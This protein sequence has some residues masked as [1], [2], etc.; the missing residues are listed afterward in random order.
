MYWRPPRSTRALSQTCVFLL[1]T[2]SCTVAE[3]EPAESK[4]ASSESIPIPKPAP[5]RTAASPPAIQ[6]IDAGG[7]KVPVGKTVAGPATYP[8]DAPNYPQATITATWLDK[9][10]RIHRTSDSPASAEKIQLYMKNELK[11][12]GWEIVSSFDQGGQYAIDATKD[13]RRIAV[14]IADGTQEV[15]S[16]ITVLI[17]L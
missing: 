1:L 16:K 13:E 12:Q 9:T 8:K 2:L 6:K 11:A 15:Q 17:T 5:E 10:G 7:Q 3:S 14:L 4:P